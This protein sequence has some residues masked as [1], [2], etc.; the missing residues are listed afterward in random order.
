MLIKVGILTTSRRI[1]PCRFLGENFGDCDEFIPIQFI[2]TIRTGAAPTS[3]LQISL[4]LTT[5]ENALLSNQ[6][7]D[8]EWQV[9]TLKQLYS[10]LVDETHTLLKTCRWRDAALARAEERLCLLVDLFAKLEALNDSQSRKTIEQLN[11]QLQR[12]LDKDKWLLA[13]TET[14]TKNTI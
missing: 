11:S 5:S 4:D 8:S 6:L 1:G 10:K 3:S 9:L 14:F 13:E 2:A 12:E 7:A